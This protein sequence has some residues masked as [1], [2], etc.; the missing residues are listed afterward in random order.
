MSGSEQ[1]PQSRQSNSGTF[2]ACSKTVERLL[3]AVLLDG[4]VDLAPRLEAGRAGLEDA[5]MHGTVEA[6]E[7]RDPAAGTGL[8]PSSSATPV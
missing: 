2:T 8:A 3:D 6:V 7:R 5:R 1:S 4:P